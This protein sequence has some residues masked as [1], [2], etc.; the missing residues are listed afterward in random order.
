M[1]AGIDFELQPETTGDLHLR[2]EANQTPLLEAFDAPEVDCVANAQVLWVAPATAQPDTAPE[3]V[4]Q[5]TK[6]PE[7]VGGVPAGAPADALDRRERF[8]GF[9]AKRA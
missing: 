3:R 5:A 7:P 8:L 6:S 4:E 2:R 1:L 9:Q